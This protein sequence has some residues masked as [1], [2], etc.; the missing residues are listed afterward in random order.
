LFGYERARRH[1]DAALERW[2]TAHSP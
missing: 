2:I 1:G